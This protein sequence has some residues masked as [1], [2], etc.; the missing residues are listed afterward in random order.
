M[1]NFNNTGA[2]TPRELDRVASK[3]AINTKVNKTVNF[4][5][6]F[7]L[8]VLTIYLIVELNT[9]VKENT[10]STYT[11]KTLKTESNM[12]EYRIAK[13]E[14]K[15]TV[16]KAVEKKPTPP[17][18]HKVDVTKPPVID[19]T[20]DDSF[21]D[22][23]NAVESGPDDSSPIETGISDTVD[24]KPSG[25]ATSNVNIVSEVPLF[26]GCSSS[27]DR[28]D[29]IECLNLKMGKFVQRWFDTSHTDNLN[30]RDQVRIS[31]MFTIN[32][33]GEI[34]DI[35]IQAP[36]KELEREARQVISRLPKITPG[37]MNGEP[38]NVTYTLP[39]V[40]RVND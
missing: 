3:K 36:N 19:N 9:Q 21:A 10:T 7:C 16:K 17:V 6:G 34:Q 38:V 40:Y 24:S 20:A 33:N 13:S 8:S 27:L 12:G 39:I 23:L 1:S 35:Q 26:P 18:E 4:L 15:Q 11:T 22:Q 31:V 32:V 37:K 5:L 25:P 30:G 14:P 29:R 2:A 28:E